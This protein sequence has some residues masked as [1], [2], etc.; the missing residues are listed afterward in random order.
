MERLNYREV[1]VRGILNPVRGEDDFY[2][3]RKAR[4]FCT[5]QG[6]RTQL[7][8]WPPKEDADQPSLF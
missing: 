3:A 5:S 1:Q 8:P 6:L 2:P 7:S 4:E